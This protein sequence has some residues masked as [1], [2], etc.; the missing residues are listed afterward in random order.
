VV[1][2]TQPHI[3]EVFYADKPWPR[4][5]TYPG[6]YTLG[7]QAQSFCYNAFLAYDG[8]SWGQSNFTATYGYPDSDTWPANDRFLVCFAYN[9]ADQYP[10][11]ASSDHSI[12]GSRQ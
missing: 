2:C 7:T 1:P 11:G 4:A 3:A 12:K 6:D 10:D 8:V 5:M 9:P